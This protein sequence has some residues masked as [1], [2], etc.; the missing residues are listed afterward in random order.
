M[1][2]LK[3]GMSFDLGLHTSDYGNE[4]AISSSIFD[5]Q[6][7]FTLVL[8]YEYLDESLVLLKRRLCWQIDDVIYLRSL[9]LTDKTASGSII[10]Q[11]AKKAIEEWNMADV[12]LYDFFNATLWEQ[13]DK[14]DNFFIELELFKKR[15]NQIDSICGN[16]NLQEGNDTTFRFANFTDS[17]LD[18]S[19]APRANAKEICS[20]MAMTDVDYL[21]YFRDEQ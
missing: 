11:K 18:S 14:E 1:N 7:K 21:E 13:I 5:L 20:K 8:I 3:N 6:K 19:L 12:M 9:L 2:L 10:S 15:R 17:F 4:I 16:K